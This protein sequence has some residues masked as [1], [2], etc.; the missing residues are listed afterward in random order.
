[1]YGT[2]GPGTGY[3]MGNGFGGDFD[4]DIMEDAISLNEAMGPDFMMGAVSQRNYKA[5]GHFIFKPIKLIFI[6]A[7]RL[8]CDIPDACVRKTKVVIKRVLV[9]ELFVDD[10]KPYVATTYPPTNYP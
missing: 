3:G 9:P 10:N 7:C 2:Y 6:G 5:T 8:C 1:L 4:R